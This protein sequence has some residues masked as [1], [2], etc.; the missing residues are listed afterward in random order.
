MVL[1]SSLLNTQHYKV[2]IKGK[3]VQAR[4]KGR[5]QQLDVVER[6]AFW[7]LSTTV[8]NFTYFFTYIYN[9][10]WLRPKNVN[11]SNERKWAHI[12]KKK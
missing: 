9:L 6:G 8:T 11:K 3:V 2:R 4:E 5:A 10:P 1:D 7:S 12:Q